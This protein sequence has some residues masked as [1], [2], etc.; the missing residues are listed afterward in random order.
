[1]QWTFDGDIVG[2]VNHGTI[3][4]LTIKR[5]TEISLEKIQ[6]DNVLT[7]DLDFRVCLDRLTELSGSYDSGDNET[8]WSLPYDEDPDDLVFVDSSTGLPV[9]VVDDS[10]TPT[11]TGDYSSNSCYVGKLYTG[12][13]RLTEWYIRKDNNVAVTDA[14]LRIRSL[15]LSFENS[16]EFTVKVTPYRRDPLVH[17]F[18]GIT[19]GVTE[20]GAPARYTG[21]YRFPILADTKKTSIEIITSSYLPVYIMSGNLEGFYTTRAKVL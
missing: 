1:M 10:G 8:T 14:K 18:T 17:K 6:L 15:T 12:T 11:A 13:S 3:L 7:G 9:V 21:E 19:L 5:G 16:G 4:Y 20:F 2:M